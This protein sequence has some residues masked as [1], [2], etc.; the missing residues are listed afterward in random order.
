MSSAQSQIANRR[1]LAIGHRGAPDEAPENTLA[2]FRRALALG[3]DAIELD[4]R[5]TRDGMPV[6]IHDSTL[7]RLT[8][9]PGR[10]TGET[11]REIRTRRVGGTEPIPRLGDVLAICRGRTMVQIEI[12]AGVPVVPVIRAVRRARATSG[13]ILA[14]FSLRI[15]QEAKKQAPFIPRML[16][17]NRRASVHALARQLAQLGAAGLSIDYRVLI[18]RPASIRFFQSRGYSVWAWTVNHRRVM[19]HLAALSIDGIL[20]DYPARL[21]QVLP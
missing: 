2:S 21:K 5:V 4:V 19:R 17:A 20:S 12:K 14:S 15:L 7:G 8:G 16:I 6:V 10:V 13:V 9:R 1:P 3:V 18:S 11:W